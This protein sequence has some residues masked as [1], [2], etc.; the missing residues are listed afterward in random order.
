MDELDT[1]EENLSAITFTTPLAQI[2]FANSA[3]SKKRGAP[4][5]APSS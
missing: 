2:F 1:L 4:I 3:A 5:A